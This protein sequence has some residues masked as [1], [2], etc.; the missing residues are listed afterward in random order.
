MKF[1]LVKN[2][3]I[4][5]KIDTLITTE[6]GIQEYNCYPGMK[7]QRKVIN[8]KVTADSFTPGTVVE[9]DNS[10]WYRDN[11]TFQKHDN[12]ILYTEEMDNLH[13]QVM[14]Q[15]YVRNVIDDEKYHSTAREVSFLNVHGN[16]GTGK[17][18][19]MLA[20]YQR[21]RA[22]GF[23]VIF[24]QD[25][26]EWKAIPQKIMMIFKDMFPEDFEMLGKIENFKKIV[27]KE[28]YISVLWV[29]LFA[30][31]RDVFEHF[32]RK[33]ILMFDK[34][35]AIQPIPFAEDDHFSYAIRSAFGLRNEVLTVM[36]VTTELTPPFRVLEETP[37]ILMGYFDQEL[38]NYEANN[39]TLGTLAGVRT[40]MSDSTL[41]YYISFFHPFYAR[42]D[43]F[44]RIVYYTNGVPSVVNEFLKT[45]MP[46]EY[47]VKTFTTSMKKHISAKW[48]KFIA[49]GSDLAFSYE[50][51]QRAFLGKEFTLEI[52]LK[53]GKN[54]KFSQNY[55]TRH[56]GKQDIKFLT[57][58]LR[59]LQFEF[60]VK[61]RKFLSSFM[62]MI[63]E[64]LKQSSTFTPEGAALRACTII[65]LIKIQIITKQRLELSLHQCLFQKNVPKQSISAQSKCKTFKCSRIACVFD[66]FASE[67]SLKSFI[68]FPLKISD[69]GNYFFLVDQQGRKFVFFIASSMFEVNQISHFFLDIYN[70]PGEAGEHFLAQQCSLIVAMDE[71]KFMQQQIPSNVISFFDKI[72]LWN[73]YEWLESFIQ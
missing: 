53:P 71:G 40:G 4:P 16:S 65:S 18:Y 13:R 28:D 56:L 35:E 66:D 36:S 25:C 10:F 42:E 58:F 44:K 47:A 21:L 3:I 23:H 41:R 20:L 50:L 9:L 27:S 33:L 34:V 11:I 19:N 32:D 55:L 59:D 1:Q 31:V 37:E 15:L 8:P 69:H 46:L 72:Y 43:Y 5:L 45:K 2:K 12:L 22:E 63:S 51:Y 60:L 61:K 26:Y 39:E 67:P 52:N 24:I 70:Q 17:S 54:Q 6:D 68:T 7:R 57:P 30:L 62:K 48:S 73:L 29:N 38:Q 64:T 14:E 49:D